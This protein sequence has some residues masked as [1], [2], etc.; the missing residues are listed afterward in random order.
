MTGKFG[1]VTKLPIEIT[2]TV[3]SNQVFIS[4]L[5]YFI[6]ITVIYQA[7]YVNIIIMPKKPAAQQYLHAKLKHKN[8]SVFAENAYRLSQ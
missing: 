7:P 4:D 1:F 8:F 6:F 2:E 5:H 3:I